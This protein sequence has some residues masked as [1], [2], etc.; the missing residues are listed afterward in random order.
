MVQCSSGVLT[1][2]VIRLSYI[3]NGH[4]HPFPPQRVTTCSLRYGRPI[5]SCSARQGV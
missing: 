3:Y 2:F 4:F 1:D 5:A